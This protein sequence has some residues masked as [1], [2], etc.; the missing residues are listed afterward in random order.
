MMCDFCGRDFSQGQITLI[1]EK[2]ENGEQRVFQCCLDYD[3]CIDLFD[4]RINEA[5]EHPFA[6]LKGAKDEM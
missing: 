3:R 4:Q 2:L 6:F 5:R 1:K